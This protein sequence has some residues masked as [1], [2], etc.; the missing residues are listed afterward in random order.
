MLLFAMYIWQLDGIYNVC[1]VIS[2]EKIDL[3]FG[4][5]FDIAF[6]GVRASPGV[7]L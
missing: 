2:P 5:D 3:C 4:Q 6:T 7:V 1:H